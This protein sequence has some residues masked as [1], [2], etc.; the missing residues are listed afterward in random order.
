MKGWGPQRTAA[1]PTYFS[2]YGRQPLEFMCI[3]HESK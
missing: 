1:T 3:I 2:S